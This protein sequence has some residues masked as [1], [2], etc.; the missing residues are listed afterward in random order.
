MFDLRL[1]VVIYP[2]R[3]WSDWESRPK[4][5][6][7]LFCGL[8]TYRLQSC[9]F[10]DNP[11][12]KSPRHLNQNLQSIRISSVEWTAR[13]VV[14]RQKRR[15]G[16]ILTPMQVFQQHAAM[17]YLSKNV[18]KSN[19]I[20]TSLWLMESLVFRSPRCL[21][22]VQLDP[23]HPGSPPFWNKV[24]GIVEETRFIQ[25]SMVLKLKF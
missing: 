15:T 18:S 22:F 20:P 21:V 8:N 9:A 13:N 7:L 1:Q 3:E 4:Q 11:L 5:R 19:F 12:H 25:I 10:V 14:L 2:E 23:D 6:W 24:Y 17:Y 16:H